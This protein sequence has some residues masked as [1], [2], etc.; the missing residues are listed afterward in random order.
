MTL[1]FYTLL[2]VVERKRERERKKERERERE[3]D[4]A[5]HDDSCVRVWRGLD[6]WE[7]SGGATGNEL[8]ISA[9]RP[10]L[11]RLRNAKRE[12]YRVMGPL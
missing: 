3:R 9:I 12:E 7:G 10:D 2:V 4:A 6:R 8:T 1:M 11:C 5:N